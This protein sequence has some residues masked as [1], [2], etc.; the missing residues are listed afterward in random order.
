MSR[1]TNHPARLCCMISG[2]GRTVMNLQDVID[3]GELDA[4]IALVIASGPCDGIERCER[5]GLRVVT[6]PGVIDAQQL[7][8]TLREHEID[9][10]VLAGY[11]KIV[12]IPAGFEGRVVNIHPALL[13]KFGGKGMHGSHVHEAV[14]AAGE[15]QS[16]CTVHLCDAQYDTGQMLLQATCPVLATDTPATLAARVFAVECEAYPRAIAMLIASLS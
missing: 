1:L 3:R 5:R 2:G 9:L 15:T 6:M 14:I 4:S 8:A 10:V 12:R 7:G 16:G 11:L 13:P